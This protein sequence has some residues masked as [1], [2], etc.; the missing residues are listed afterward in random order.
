MCRPRT[1]LSKSHDRTRG[2]VVLISGD[3]ELGLNQQL[4][5][6]LAF[7][8]HREPE[9]KAVRQVGVDNMLLDLDVQVRDVFV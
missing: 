5:E 4:G 1:T 6:A 3:R 2:F 7:L 9:L 8:D